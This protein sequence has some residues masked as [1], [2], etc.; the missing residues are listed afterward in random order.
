M[1]LN[2]AECGTVTAGG[3]EITHLPPEARGISYVPQDLA[4]FPHLSVDGN[5]F[6][7]E[8]ARRTADPAFHAR[9]LDLA[10][11]IG[12]APLF[13]RY[14]AFLSGGEKQ[15]VAL[16]RALASGNRVLLLDEPF[17][18]LHEGFRAEIWQLTR[19]LCRE[20]G[21][22]TIL[23]SHDLRE[24]AYLADALTV[25]HDGRVVA[26]GA[27]SEILERPKTMSLAHLAGL[28]NLWPAEVVETTAG[29][30]VIAV[31]S[32]GLKAALPRRPEWQAG[33]KVYLGAWPSA[34][35]L[36]TAQDPCS[37]S[38]VVAATVVR[39]YGLADQRT[40]VCR[41]EGGG[42]VEA[43]V[44]WDGS[45]ACALQPS[46]RVT[47][48]FPPERLFLVQHDELR[49]TPGVSTRSWRSPA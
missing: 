25:M 17:S 5:V 37:A 32:L 8:R 13:H 42:T 16:L 48:F 11:R 33:T 15:R 22:A 43:C 46:A 2:R 4:L 7:A 9:I 34:V 38:P 12:I 18:A 20:F 36:C 27:P 31:P 41:A 49:A 3:R 1:G 30:A 29:R 10:E 47:L 6:Y 26:S 21:I 39:H 35:R 40:I 45:A 24:I 14:P 23:V 19:L 44:P 28:R